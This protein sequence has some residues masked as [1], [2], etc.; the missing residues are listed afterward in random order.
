MLDKLGLA[1]DQ[2]ASMGTEKR[3]AFEGRLKEM[4]KQRP[5][6]DPTMSAQTGLIADIK[7]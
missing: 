5:E 6:A 2:L 3:K 4:V 1:E 7:A